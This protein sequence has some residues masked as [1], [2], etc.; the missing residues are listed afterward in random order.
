MYKTYHLQ[1]ITNYQGRSQCIQTL[2]N[3]ITNNLE[4]YTYIV[5]EHVSQS[6][7]I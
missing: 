7:I 5:I 6:L 3:M 1:A 4:M 2:K